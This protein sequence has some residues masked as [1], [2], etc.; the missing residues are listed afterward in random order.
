MCGIVGFTHV[1]R[2]SNSARLRDATSA[3]EHRGPDQHGAFE[4]EHVS[5]GAVR[6]KII[7][8]L[9]GEQPMFSEDRRTVVVLN[10]E[11]YNHRELR[12]ELE[13]AG[14][15]FSTQCDTEV[16]LQAFLRWDVDC[17]QRLRGMFAYTI[18]DSRERSL[19]LVRDR[20]GKKP[21]YYAT[22]PEGLYFGSELKCLRAVGV[23]LEHDRPALQLYFLLGYIPDPWTPYLAIRKLAPGGWLRSRSCR[24]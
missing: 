18:W 5:L 22:L 9:A 2:G 1:N 11:I 19:L 4:S 14:H 24:P 7:D 15:H 8:L 10:G 3:L 16:V 21:L 17:F 6:L 20:F 12:A 13:A 23:P